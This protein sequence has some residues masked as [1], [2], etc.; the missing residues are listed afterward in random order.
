MFDVNEFLHASKIPICGRCNKPGHTKRLNQNSTFGICRRCGGVDRSNVEQ[1]NDCRLKCHNCGGRHISID[2]KC[3]LMDQLR[4]EL[5]D[6][7]KKHPEK[8]PHN[9]QLFIIISY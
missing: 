5:I 4:H 8:L 6:E 7:L 1:H 3:P 2:Y 9:I